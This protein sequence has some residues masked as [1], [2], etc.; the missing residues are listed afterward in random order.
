ML[1]ILRINKVVES[2]PVVETDLPAE[3]SML[4]FSMLEVVCFYVLCGSGKLRV[5]V[6]YRPPYYDTKAQRY[7]EA[8]IECL[9]KH[10]CQR[11]AN[12]IV[13]DFSCPKVKWDDEYTPSSDYIHSLQMQFVSTA[14]LHQ[15]VQFATRGEN[16]LDLVLSTD[17]QIINGVSSGPPLGHSDHVAVN[18]TMRLKSVGTRSTQSTGGEN[19]HSYAWQKADYEALA[20]FL[21]NV[22]WYSL[23]CHNPSAESAWIAFSDT[24][25]TAINMFVPKKR[26][27]NHVKKHYPHEIRKFKK[28]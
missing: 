22:D 10:L 21:S 23:V 3:F 16:V 11:H 1:L 5:F 19:V 4:E 13:G 26:C 8:L 9:D 25:L 7:M 17:N 2:M 15:F 27:S 24:L 20:Y 12:V 18:F 14:G 6:I 28:T